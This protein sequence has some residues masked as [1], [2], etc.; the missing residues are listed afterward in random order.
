ML[1][2][3]FNLPQCIVPDKPAK[4]CK[5]L[6]FFLIILIT[7]AASCKNSDRRDVADGLYANYSIRG[8]EGKEFVTAFF[9]FFDDPVERA[10]VLR[11]PAKVFLDGN[12]LSPDSAKETGGFYEIQLPIQDFT[13]AHTIRF[14]DRENMEHREEFFFTPFRLMKEIKDSLNRK[15]MMF[16]VEGLRDQDVVRVVITDTSFESEGVNEMDTI[17]SQRLDLRKHLP[18]I[19]NGPVT[20]YLFKE[21]E[22]SLENKSSKR[23]TISITYSLKREFELKD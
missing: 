14:I 23:G 10:L 9:Q 16:E 15:D 20:L 17:I 5:R 18:A 4:M 22:R 13:G 1:L 8:E 19:S 7:A 12:L 21:E 3:L 11:K 6:F 2:I